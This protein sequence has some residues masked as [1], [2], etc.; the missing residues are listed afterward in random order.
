LERDIFDEQA[1]GCIGPERL[2][3]ARRIDDRRLSG[4]PLYGNDSA[5]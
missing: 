2:A 4:N 1:A 5:R 3:V